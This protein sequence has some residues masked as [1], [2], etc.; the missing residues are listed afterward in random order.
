MVRRK[1]ILGTLAVLA[2]LA[3]R[4]AMADPIQFTGNVA[5]DF[6]GTGTVTI[7]NHPYAGTATSNP[8]AVFQAPWITQQGSINGWVFKDIRFN[9]DKASDTLAVG[10]NY[11]GIA[12]DADGNGVQGKADPR[13]TAAGGVELPHLGAPESISV[14][15]D[16][17][18]DKKYDI[19]AGV[20]ANPSQ[21]GPGLDGFNV[22]T[23]QPSS[24]GIENN[25]GSTLAGHLGKLAFDP[26]KGTKDFEFTITN[27]SKLP[28][29]DLTKGFGF[30]VYSGS[31][32]DVIAGEDAMGYTLVG[33]LS[34]ETLHTP[35][36]ATLLAWSLVASAAAWR[37]RRRTCSTA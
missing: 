2:L 31:P 7:V 29:L 8:N 23:Y 21:R 20:S 11:F 36:P 6:T 28:G 22:A 30:S 24:Q 10:L 14:A 3:A 35:E 34:P 19:V 12:G 37:T 13:T 17:N 32:V 27:F 16:L 9:Y 25:Y 15:L 5:Q 18:R 26:Q 1:P 4:S 33:G